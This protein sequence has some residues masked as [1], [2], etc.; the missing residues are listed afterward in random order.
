MVN[1]EIDGIPLKVD[2]TKMIIQAAD[3][4]GIDIP[5]FC[6]HKK[7]SI[8]ANCRMCL[9]EVDKARKA[10]PA[11]ATPVTEGMKIFTHSKTAIAAQRS[12]MEFLLINHP[13]D[14]PI[15]DQGGECEL[16]DLSVGYGSGVGRFSENKRVV[17][18]KNIGPLIN[19][20]MTRCIHCTR[21]VRFGEE[22]AGIK[23]LGATGRGEHME[24]GTYIEHSLASELSG[25]I[26]DLCPVGALTSKPFRYRARAWELTAHPS[27]APHDAIGSNI[28]FHT[29]GNEIL[30]VVPRDNENVNETWLSDRDRFS[31]LGLNHEQR[32][33]NPMIKQNGKWQ[34]VGWETALQTAIDGLKKI[35]AD[36]GA[37]KIAGLISPSATLEEAYLFQ[38]LLRGLG[39]NNIDHRLR[40]QDFSDQNCDY[41][42]EE[43]SLADIEQ[44]DD[45]VLV[46]CNIR[47]E[48]PIIAHRVRQSVMAGA[49]VTDINFFASDLL[50]S[51][52]KQVT[53]NA[54]EMLTTLSGIAKALIPLARDEDTTAWNDYLDD[55]VPS[56][57]EQTIAMQLS[58]AT[59]GMLFVGSLAVTHPQAATIKALT[60]LIAKLS[61]SRLIVLPTANSMASAIASALPYVS[62]AQQSANSVGLDAQQSWQQT[63]PSYVLFGVEPELDCANPVLAQQ[64]LQQAS[65]VVS[66][67]SY[68]SDTMLTYADVILPIASF[69][70]TSG[71]F[72]G[73]DGQW[74]S[75]TGA[76]TAKGE[77]RPGW[78]VLRVLANVAKLNDFDYVSSQDVRDDVQDQIKATQAIDKASY[79]PTKQNVDVAL[80]VISEVPMYQSD[81]VVR[82]SSA[83]QQTPNNQ[84]ASIARMNADEA[85]RYGVKE[86]RYITVTQADNAITVPFEIDNTIADG[87][88]YIAAGTQK[89]SHLGSAFG[90]VS[91][92]PTGQGE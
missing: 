65:F 83:L 26:I 64:S 11:C 78:K 47:A 31:Y 6:Y 49:T 22:I 21:C 81:S 90:S 7:L 68:V 59:Q 67:N 87:C 74:Q 37:E 71:T 53:V 40:Q 19:T 9:V 27:I 33:T 29:R 75:F 88:I 42:H 20:D 62:T 25:N 34:Q 52:D 45:I 70:E 82:R 12:V 89:T 36:Y 17:K 15:C 39:S 92:E 60:N 80:M 30:R 51:V 28:E 13:L 10:L 35:K 91:V 61:H 79:I 63:L 16:Q 76:V 50:M 14:C 2:S 84:R 58:N 85:E 3:E 69:A 57:I 1:I 38:K 23:E 46:G 48:Q 77:S 72:I 66:M 73:V 4:A 41:D 56:A 5:R 43:W 55:V 54:K 24:I 18:D 44:S 32:A 8:A 86:E